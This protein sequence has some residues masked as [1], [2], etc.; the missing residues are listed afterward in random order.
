MI[1]LGLV[2][3]SGCAE[4]TPFEPTSEPLDDAGGNATSNTTVVPELVFSSDVVNGTAP[5]NVTF[6]I[7]MLNASD[8]ANI[9][10]T[11][12]IGDLVDD[13]RGLPAE[14]LFTLDV[15]N[16]T[17]VASV[18]AGGELF[19]ASQDIFVEAVPEAPP[20]ELPEVTH[21]EFGESLGCVG[22][23]GVCVGPE[24]GED[25]LDG[26]W[27]ELGEAYWGLALSSTVDNALGDS[28]CYFVD[29]AGSEVGNANNGGGPC[30]GTVPEGAAQMYLYS[31]AEPAL[32]QTLEFTLA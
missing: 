23:F 13:G 32:G 6:S 2:A 21:F 25:G 19:E 11:I 31:Y 30:A 4:T 22:D 9:T 17:A 3:L 26:F 12:T 1:T 20:R 15:G 8:A 10:W 5:L 16:H 14:S 18:I 24:I 7:D 27:V 28:D 29:E